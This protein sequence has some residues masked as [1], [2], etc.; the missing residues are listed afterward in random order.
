MVYFW[1]T[2]PGWRF[3][4]VVAG[5]LSLV[6]AL[7]LQRVLEDEKKEWRPENIGAWSEIRKFASYCTVPTFATIVTQGC[8]GSIPWQA[9]SFNTL[10]FQ[11]V[12]MTNFDAGVVS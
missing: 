1:G 3:A 7:L 4:L 2:V 6:L 9:M 12:G 10:Y 5:L 11:Y 8:F